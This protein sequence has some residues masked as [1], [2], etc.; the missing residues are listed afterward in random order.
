MMVVKGVGQAFIGGRWITILPGDVF[1]APPKLLHATRNLP[2][3]DVDFIVMACSAPPQIEFYQRIG[4]FKN[5]LFDFEAIDKAL[6]R[7]VRGNISIV[8][9]TTLND[10]GEDQRAEIKGAAEVSRSG[11]I[12]NVYRGA[13]FYANGASMRFAVW[14]GA[15]SRM[16]TC[17]AAI[18]GPGEVFRP[19]IHPISED[20]IVCNRGVGQGHLNGRWI[21]M[22]AGD[23]LYAPAG[24]TH[25]TGC[26]ADYPAAMHTNGCACPPQMDLYER[27]GYLVDG[28]FVDSFE[29]SSQSAAPVR[30]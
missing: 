19:H 21:H 29:W 26:P 11:G 5:G 9:E 6:A 17:H 25:G 16:I 13:P 20:A 1:Y 7:S 28:R 27:G 3:S 15:G 23:I 12:F 8:D 30:K 24:I 22:D 10:T 18:H 4:F 2:G 14:P